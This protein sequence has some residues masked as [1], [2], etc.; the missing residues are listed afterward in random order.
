VT[1][2]FLSSR[3]DFALGNDASVAIPPDLRGIVLQ[4]NFGLVMRPVDSLTPVRIAGSDNAWGP[5]VSPHSDSVAFTT[6]SPGSVMVLPIGGGTPRS[7]ASDGNA[8]GTSWSDDGWIYYIQIRTSALA[9]VRASGGAVEIVATPDSARDGLLLLWPQ[10]L[11]GGRGVLVTIWHRRGSPEIGVVNLATRTLEPLMPG[12]RGAFAAPHFLHVLQGDGRLLVTRFDPVRLKLEGTTIS[13]LPRMPLAQSGQAAFAVAPDGRFLAYAITPDPTGQVVRV[14]RQG[15]VTVV[16]PEWRQRFLTIALSPDG[17]RLAASL[18]A[19][20]GRE[21]L[22]IKDL[23]G[24]GRVRIAYRGSTNYRPTWTAR[25]DSVAFSSDAGGSFILW[26]APA[27]GRGEPRQL[28]ADALGIDEGSW[29]SDGRWLLVRTGSGGN[30]DI[31]GMRPGIDSVLSPFVATNQEETSPVLSPDNRWLA[32]VTEEGGIADVYVRPFPDV[33]R[34]RWKIST[35]GG[36]E[37][38]WSHSGR[39]LFFRDANDDLVSVPIGT[40]PGF[41]AAPPRRLFSAR[42]YLVDGRH[43]NY[44]VSPD[45]QSFYFVRM[46]D[47]DQRPDLVLVQNWLTELHAR[48]GR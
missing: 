23:A 38:R 16:D 14:N 4:S 22:W 8:Y 42:G 17:R 6:G 24:G 47:P 44:S 30:R 45:D 39:E 7:L 20:D 18:L 34:A 46:A 35:G 25:G 26:Q 28:L 32:Y 21:E 37:P 1:R 9:R 27:D 48:L 2:S 40:G 15:Q 31:Q 3:Q 41:E 43:G 11:P 13:P 29:S 10:A 12:V 19:A 33:D 36:I 5:S